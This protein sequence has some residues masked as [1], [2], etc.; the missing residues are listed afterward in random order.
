MDF[1]HYVREQLPSLLT[2][3]EPEILEE[4]TQHL[5][6][7]SARCAVYSSSAATAAIASPT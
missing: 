6:D 7:L 2:P 1:R 3:R 4:L 5:E